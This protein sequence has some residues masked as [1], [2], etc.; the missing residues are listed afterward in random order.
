MP[1]SSYGVLYKPSSSP[2]IQPLTINDLKKH[3]ISYVRLQW[4]DFANSVKCR[5]LS[6]SYFE[7]LLQGPRPGIGIVTCLAVS[8]RSSHLTE[9]I[10]VADL[11]T[12]RLCPYAPGH[13]S[14]MGHFQYK[15]PLQKGLNDS[16]SFSHPFCTRTLL[17]RIVRE[18]KTEFGIDYLV[19]FETEFMLLRS[20]EPLVASDI[21]RSS[22]SEALLTG[23]P[24]ATVMQEIADSLQS[25]GIDLVLYHAE[26]GPGQYEV[27]TG[28]LAP[29]EAVDAL[30]HTHET[31]RNTA[32]KRGLFASF[33]PRLFQ[34]SAGNGLHAHI[35]LH[36]S[37]EEGKQHPDNLSQHE[38]S[39]L[40]GILDHL[41]GLITLTLP[42]PPSYGRMKDGIRTN[43]TFVCWGIETREAPVRV[44]DFASPSSRRFEFRA[45]DC[46]ANPY[47]A[48]AGVLIAGYAGI[49][50]A[51]TLTIKD[52]GYIG[53][54]ELDEDARQALGIHRRLPLSWEEAREVFSQDQV[55]QSFLDKE[56]VTEYMKANELIGNIFKQNENSPDAMSR[57]AE[58]Y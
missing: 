10:Y 11:S 28:P 17:Q 12:L 31:I 40:A 46:T 45:L 58:L 32:S 21:H 16:T 37:K 19:G 3:G 23:T 49:K 5:V 9:S 43:S 2:V 18:T 4:V 25:S 54:S 8:S 55:L 42:T 35:S 44:K 51:R 29:L 56:F 20:T 7:K 6:M 36:S 39:F 48:L 30:V 50:S 57:L 13:A 1:D 27:V 33:A 47:I 26:R 34:K 38:T 14:V 52:I 22:G 41:P 24:A 53:A 15:T